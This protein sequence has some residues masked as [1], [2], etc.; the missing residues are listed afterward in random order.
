VAEYTGEWWTPANPDLKTRGTLRIKNFYSILSFF[1]NTSLL[2]EKSYYYFKSLGENLYKPDIILGNSEGR[3]IT[4]LKCKGYKTG[5]VHKVG[6][7]NPFINVP[8][9]YP[10]TVFVGAHFAK[11]E[12]IHFKSLEISYQ[13]LSEWVNVFEISNKIKIYQ[14]KTTS[15]SIDFQ[16]TKSYSLNEIKISHNALVKIEHLSKEGGL[17]EKD[18]PI[19]NYIRDFLAFGMN[20]PIYPFQIK[21]IT[22]EKKIVSKKFN[23]PYYHDIKIFTSHM[24]ESIEENKQ[25]LP[26]MMLFSL[27][28]ITPKVENVINRWFEIMK[29]PLKVVCDLYL[30]T[31]YNPNP[32]SRHNFL[33]LIQAFEAFYNESYPEEERLIITKEAYNTNVYKELMKKF[34][35]DILSKLKSKNIESEK[36]Q[37]L[38]ENLNNKLE[39]GNEVSLKKKLMQVMED[40]KY[41]EVINLVIKKGKEK[42]ELAYKIAKIRNNLS[43]GKEVSN[44]EVIVVEKKLGLLIKII[45][46]KALNFEDE[47]V[48][49][50]L[51]LSHT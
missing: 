20:F 36:I 16:P 11:R 34:D 22:E 8:I 4:L 1:Q 12:D 47:E 49:N 21:G 42:K 37:E 35:S 27:K 6:Q 23:K 48:I 39:Y 51:K 45:L 9:Y 14:D 44:D 43:H 33:N 7:S 40:P 17:F 28:D 13:H 26:N 15:V 25:L 46:L 10:S 50:F 18:L 5:I 19:I 2:T 29:S 32:Y 38:R 41:K 24:L 31:L 3:E 30:G